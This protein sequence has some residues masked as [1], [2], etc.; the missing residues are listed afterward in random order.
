MADSVPTELIEE[1]RQRQRELAH[2]V[3]ERSLTKAP[4]VIA[5]VDVHLR[6]SWGV[7]AAVAYTYPS[8]EEIDHH[9][10]TGR[11]TFPYIPGLL[12][13]REAP[14]CL[15]AIRGLAQEP[16]LILADGQGR[17]HPRRAGIACHL[18]V[19]LGLPTIGVAK[20]ILVGRH[21][22]LGEERGSV[23]PLVADDEVVGMAVRTRTGVTPVYVSV[24]H[25]IT[26]DEAV[27][28]T[29]RTTTRYRLPEPS[30]RAHLLAQDTARTLP[31]DAPG[32]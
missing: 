20:S 6:G 25:L 26:L 3:I 1:Y 14:L 2:A 4:T 28:W 27:D 17:A 5:A 29:L 8:L 19:E 24:G 15:E 12:S 23:A 9:V 10:A 11:L 7:A 16:D 13:Y 32:D 31:T 22:P 18:G 30:R 21:D